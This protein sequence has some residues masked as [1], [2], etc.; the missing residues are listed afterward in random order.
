MVGEVLAPLRARYAHWL[1]LDGEQVLQDREEAAQDV[2]ALQ[3]LVRMER[4]RPPSWHRALALAA[5]GSAAICLDP[6]PNPAVNG[7]ILSGRIAPG[8]FG[9]S[10]G[11]AGVLD[12]KRP[13]ICPGS[14]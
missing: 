3:L 7:T 14:P 10:P 5:S 1:G 6:D 9:R 4:D 2:R 8:I 12:G 11:G 13:L